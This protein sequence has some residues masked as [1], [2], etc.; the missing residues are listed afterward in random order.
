MSVSVIQLAKNFVL[1][2]LWPTRCACC[3]AFGRLLCDACKRKLQFIDR[4]NSCPVCGAPFSRVEC[5][6]CSETMLKPLGLQR[7]PYDACVSAVL[8]DERSK[9]VVTNY[10]DGGDQ[11]LCE[12][13]GAIMADVTPAAWVEGACVSFLPASAK[14][15]RRRGWD[16]MSKLADAYGQLL[17]LPVVELFLPPVALD[18]R[19][20]SRRERFANMSKAVSLLPCAKVPE[21][22]ILVDDVY[23][24]GSTLFAATTKLKEVRPGVEV[25]CITFARA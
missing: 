7:A 12:V 9:R 22:V 1:E 4:L 25:F 23:T 16:H 19:V 10:K 15:L 11:G 20:L 5:C 21:R 8:F 3:D 17:G 6:D 18:Q 13:L 2:T 14:A 24:T